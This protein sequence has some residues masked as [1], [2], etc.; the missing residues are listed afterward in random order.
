MKIKL[1]KKKPLKQKA[2][3][4]EVTHMALTQYVF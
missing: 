2:V 4:N 3:F 1:S